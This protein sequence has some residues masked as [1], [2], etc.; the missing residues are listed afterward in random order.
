MS[1]EERDTEIDYMNDTIDRLEAEIVA[2]DAAYDAKDAAY[3]KLKLHLE[4]CQDAYDRDI[5]F[6]PGMLHWDLL[7]ATQ[8]SL[9]EHMEII[10]KL[11]DQYDRDAEFKLLHLNIIKKH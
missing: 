9:R 3:E 7:Q 8:E 5:E 11:H 6:K 1:D 10:K 2:K 4:T